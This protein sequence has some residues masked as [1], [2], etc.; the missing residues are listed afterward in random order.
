[1]ILPFTFINNFV[2]FK[3]NLLSP[4]K[5]NIY[6]FV[7]LIK[8]TVMKVLKRLLFATA[9]IVVVSSAVNAQIGVGV[10]ISAR[11]AP[12]A[13]PLYS[14]PPCPVNGY[15]W[16]PGYWGWNTDLADY[17]WIPG[18]WAAP[19]RI[20]YLWT[21]PY[22]GYE[23]GAYLFHS[24]YWGPHIGFYGGIRY[25]YGYYGTGFVGGGWAGNVFRYNTA[26]VN[27]N[28]TVVQNT[29]VDRTV[30]NNTTVNRT[31]FNGP[32]GINAQPTHEENTAMQEDHQQATSEQQMHEQ[33]AKND[34]KQLNANN[35]GE[36]RNVSM[37]RADGNHFNSR[38]R[39][40]Q[41]HGGGGRRP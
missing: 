10:S 2:N 8:K 25:G 41:Y 27:V 14:Q 30:V 20:G 11:I 15:L 28:R 1:M 19:P 40:F 31:S 29:Y 7:L 21:P 36:P 3:I 38:G 33:N 12:P 16:T 35:H 24:G 9:L 5:V 18:V 39:S 22:W 23:S 34:S 6:T 13:L 17:Y 26:V 4:F 37:D 32:N